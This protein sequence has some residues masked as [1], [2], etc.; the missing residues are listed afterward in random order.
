MQT[1]TTDLARFTS[2]G[3]GQVRHPGVAK[4]RRGD[5]VAVTDDGADTIEAEVLDLVGQTAHVQVHM[6]RILHRA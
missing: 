5:L 6:D 3:Y 1:F 4:L 2:T